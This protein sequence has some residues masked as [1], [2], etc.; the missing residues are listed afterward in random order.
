MRENII[1]WGIENGYLKEVFGRYSYCYYD[2]ELGR[3]VAQLCSSFKEALKE[4]CL[5]N[6]YETYNDFLNSDDG[7]EDMIYPSKSYKATEKLKSILL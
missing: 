1:L 4:A 5:D 6:M 7:D 2:E 3:D